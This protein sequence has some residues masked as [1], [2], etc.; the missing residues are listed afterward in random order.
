MFLSEIDQM[1]RRRI[2]A[3]IWKTW[4]RVKTRFKNLKKLGVNKYKAWEWANT[5]K[6]YARVS[7]SFILETTITNARL[8][9]RGLISAFKYYSSIR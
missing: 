3:C 8:E 9:K 4:K 7:N 1:I 2:R 5:R 6:G